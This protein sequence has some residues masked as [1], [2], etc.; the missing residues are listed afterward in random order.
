M[1]Q[2]TRAGGVNRD[3]L[4][5]ALLVAAGCLLRAA[6]IA[7]FAHAP[8]SD[9]LAYQSMALNLIGGNGILEN[10]N[11]AFYNAG[12][13]LF[14]L[15]PVFYLFGDGLLAPRLANLLLGG[16]AIVLCYRVAQEAGAGR[17]GRLLAAAIWALYVPTAVYGVYLA[18]ENLMV[19]L[20][21]GVI[22]CAL[23]LAK[24]PSLNVAAG[25]GV[26]FGLLAL[27]GNAALSLA[28]VVLLAL[29]VAPG[30]ARHRILLS[31]TVCV[32]A[33]AVSAPWMIRNWSVLGAPVMNTNGGFNLYLGNN[34]AANGF[35][36]SI[37][38]TPRGPTWHELRKGGEVQAAETLK[39][40]AV[41]WIAEHPGE[42]LAL[43]LK[44]A[45]Y[46][47]APPLHEGKGGNASKAEAMVRAVWAIQFVALAAAALASLA[48]RRLRN[49]QLA[50]LWL[51][52][53]SYTGV[54]ML[55]YVIFRYREPIMP[56]LGVMAALALEA[57]FQSR[58]ERRNAHLA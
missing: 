50:V 13:P 20:M 41:S 45:V 16:V 18:K 56:I 57:Y 40:E 46:F 43:A 53:V 55:F 33:L 17:I 10:G 7:G 19:P 35:F 54:H 21:L 36:V 32:V 12:Y 2:R 1:V 29:F 4:W 31:G 37:A 5:L 23:R 26:L 11:R 14:V 27:T 47:W 8:E 28:S 51:A 58:T 15:A 34:P 39:R 42:F 24:A 25:C 44:K 22:W 3:W 52:V 30:A 49:R 6:A 38:D 48:I 9:E